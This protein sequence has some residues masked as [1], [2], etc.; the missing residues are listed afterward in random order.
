M[1]YAFVGAV[2]YDKGASLN[3]KPS[4]FGIYSLLKRLSVNTTAIK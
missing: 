4:T 1:F 3:Y 2:Y